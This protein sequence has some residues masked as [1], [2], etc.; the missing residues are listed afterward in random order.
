VSIDYPSLLFDPIYQT[1]GVPARLTPQSTGVGV[2]VTVLDDTSGAVVISGSLGI[3]TIK[4]AASIRGTELVA[5]DLL[6]KDLAG[7]LA[8]LTLRPGDPGEVTWRIESYAL[9]PSPSG[10]MAGEIQLVLIR[11]ES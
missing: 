9:K 5:N 4:P 8:R 11:T 7:P 3:Q 6:P 10:E 2:D 1:M